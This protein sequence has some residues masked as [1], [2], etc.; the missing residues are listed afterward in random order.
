MFF[1]FFLEPLFEW[2]YITVVWMSIWGTNFWYALLCIFLRN[3]PLLN[4]PIKCAKNILIS[5]IGLGAA[6]M[7]LWTGLFFLPSLPLFLPS[8]FPL[9]SIFWTPELTIYLVLYVHSRFLWKI[10]IKMVSQGPTKE[11]R[12]RRFSILK[13]GKERSRERWCPIFLNLFTSVTKL[14]FEGS[15]IYKT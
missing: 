7:E 14:G 5:F 13:R 15:D 3:Y 10:W 12:Q 2:L 8:F 4:K 6:E 11:S 9:I 1:F